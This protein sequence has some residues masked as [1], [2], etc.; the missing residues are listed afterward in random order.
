MW[1]EVSTEDWQDAA[2]RV[3]DVGIHG[4]YA[5]QGTRGSIRPGMT[6]DEML[7][8]STRV[9]GRQVPFNSNAADCLAHA[10]AADQHDRARVITNTMI[11]IPFDPSPHAPDTS[12]P[13]AEEG[14]TP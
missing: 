4:V 5:G 1:D 14:P 3:G 6:A 13:A 8:G 9:S 12:A 7:A 11:A 10:V 2:L